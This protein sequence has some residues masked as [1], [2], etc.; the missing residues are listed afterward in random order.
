MIRKLSKRP[1]VAVLAMILSSL[2]IVGCKKNDAQQTGGNASVA[3]PGIGRYTYHVTTSTGINQD[4]TGTY[5]SPRD[6]AGGKVE[7]VTYVV[8]TI[9]SQATI[10]ANASTTTYS[11]TPP[12]SFWGEIENFQTTPGLTK[13]TV[14]GWPL[15]I[16]IKNS[17][18]TGDAMTFTGGPVT[19]HI[20]AMQDN[21]HITGD[22]NMKYQNGKAV[23]V[24][25]SITTP[26]GTFSCNEWA[27]E[28][29][30][31]FV[32]GPVSQTQVLKDTLWYSPKVGMV[33]SS[34][35]GDNVYSQTVLT[36]IQ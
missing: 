20:E 7:T 18:S 8:D 17:P 29:Y 11:V 9:S 30:T 12:P 19:M 22:W 14:S 24:N 32:A 10:Y 28:T 31:S 15:Y 5:S 2:L 4:M 13:L 36:R 23:A 25:Q 35:G 26:A 16:T 6:S 34:E 27:Y 33:K 3:L 1:T 21:M